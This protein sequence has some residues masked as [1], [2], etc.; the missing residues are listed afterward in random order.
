ML[1]LGLALGGSLYAGLSRA[2]AADA[3][4]DSS[5]P[6]ESEVV[7]TA[8]E[9][10]AEGATADVNP[11]KL[12]TIIVTGERPRPTATA[13][14]KSSA[15]LIEI[16]Q[17]ITVISSELLDAQQV[18]SVPEALRYVAG[19]RPNQF[20]R[21]GFDDFVIRGFTQ[22]AFTF[23]DGL[24]QD[25][26]FWVQQEPFGLDSIEVLKGPASILYGQVGPGG[27]INL[28]SKSPDG[29]R[30]G[31]AELSLGQYDFRRAAADVQGPLGSSGQWAYRL[32][33]VLVD[34]E[35]YV[36]FVDADRYTLAPS[37]SWTPAP[38]TR[39][40]F[41]GSY[42]RDRYDRIFGLPAAGTVLPN[43]NGR[44]PSTR[45]TGEPDF[46]G[47]DID[48]LQLGYAAEHALNE[49]WTLK[50][51]LRVNQYEVLGRTMFTGALQADQRSLA[52]SPIEQQVDNQ[53]FGVDTQAQWTSTGT[54]QHTVLLGIDYQ[55]FDNRQDNPGG[56]V[57][58]LDLFAPQ[59][60]AP[61]TLDG[62][63]ITFSTDQV[64][65]QLGFY[66]QDQVRLGRWVGL[67]G[68]R[69]DRAK[70]DNRNLL[71]GTRREQKDDAVTGRVGLVYL[72]ES[73]F[74]PYASFSQSFLPISGNRAD[75]GQFEP[76]E[77][78][79]IET[80]VKYEN[81]QGRWTAQLAV[82]EIV[83]QNLTT[84]DPDNPGFSIQVGEQTHRGAELETAVQLTPAWDLMLAYAYLDAEVTRSN[85]GTQGKRPPNVPKNS[86]SL[87]STYE[88]ALAGWGS[89]GVG[90]GLR[91]VQDFPGDAMNTFEVPDYTVF[92]ATAWWQRG[93]WRL[94][95][96]GKNL[97][98][99]VH[100]T[101]SGSINSVFAGE[102]INVSAVLRYSW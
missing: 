42:Q 90:G 36:D 14:T 87:W 57:A 82:F 55:Q 73:G 9:P 60:G 64:Q 77:G 23:R 99:K 59:Y 40:T 21:R 54:L 12:D 15:P 38:D 24:R 13:G 32:N 18:Q 4:G 16:P 3:P 68:L 50:Q 20:G 1:S 35:D 89:A 70:D 37:L 26:F 2:Q 49:A 85:S 52:R 34:R 7:E 22:S 95:V 79:Q 91:Y 78:E 5:P 92:D 33:G 47:Y 101:G 97:T 17:S 8:E 61:V 76:Q 88:F 25:P 69:Y 44:I 63:T 27:I 39:V 98:D 43:P 45:F 53:V 28:A 67:A 81:A 30:A 84:P 10:A 29:S 72:S 74:A 93:A 80:G 86:L 48:N 11:K 66:A 100:Y 94:A 96:N 83:Q 62:S 75:G 51:N 65:R 58:P 41:I 71:A 56:T 19:V 46:D 102:G 6:P 31:R